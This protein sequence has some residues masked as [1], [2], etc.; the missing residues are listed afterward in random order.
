MDDVD[1]VEVEVEVDEESDE[2]ELLEE[3][4]E[5]ESDEENDLLAEPYPA[6]A[7]LTI[8]NRLLILIILMRWQAEHL[9]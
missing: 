5:V 8:S 3:K 6:R 2:E 1:E 7:V 9:L 4:V